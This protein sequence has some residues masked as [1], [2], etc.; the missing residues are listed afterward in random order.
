MVVLGGSTESR[1]NALICAV[2][3]GSS[4]FMAA[5]LLEKCHAVSFEFWMCIALVSA[6]RKA[7]LTMIRYLLS[8]GAP[9]NGTQSHT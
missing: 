6:I 1:Q 8:K 7:D 4:V 9:I 5:K 2:E 3:Y